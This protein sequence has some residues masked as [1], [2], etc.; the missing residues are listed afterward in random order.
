MVTV[1]HT[2]IRVIDYNHC[3]VSFYPN[4]NCG[5]AQQV[6]LSITWAQRFLDAQ[7]VFWTPTKIGS[8]YEYQPEALAYKE[9]MKKFQRK[10]TMTPQQVCTINL[11]IP[12]QTNVDTMVVH[13]RSFS[14]FKKRF[15]GDMPIKQ[16]LLLIRMRGIRDD[17]HTTSTT[18]IDNYESD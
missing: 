3:D 9:S 10:I 2:L 4:A 18:V 6:I 14:R 12:V 11:P 8:G 15:T 17:Y 1:V 5:T 16:N 13:G 7:T